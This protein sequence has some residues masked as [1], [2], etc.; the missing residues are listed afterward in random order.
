M[1]IKR[2]EASD[3]RQA[4]R[5]IREE[6]GADVVI[7]SSRRVGDRV[8]VTVANDEDV[9]S[10]TMAESSRVT[11]DGVAVSRKAVTPDVRVSEA[12]KPAALTA[13]DV[14]PLGEE[15]KILRRMLET[16]V[17]QL[18]WNDRER[19]SPFSVEVLRDLSAIGFSGDIVSKLVDGIPP[20]L[21][22]SRARRLAIARLADDVTVTGD[23]W[24][25]YGGVVA[26]V[27][28]TG[29]GKT[30][31]VAKL[32]ARWV[33]R[34]GS[35]GLALI[36]CDALR[37]GGHEQVKRLGRL[38]GAQTYT[39][40]DLADLPALLA[41]LDGRRLV[42]IDTAGMSQRDE[43]WPPMLSSLH[44]ASPQMEV[45]LTLS[46]ASQAGAIEETVSRCAATP[47][48]S[49]I[50]TKLDE[51]TSLGGILSSLIRTRLAVSYLS[52]GQRIPEDLRP[53]RALDML[54]LAVSLADRSGASVDE[55]V[56]RRR[57]GGLHGNA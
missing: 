29:V 7:L 50:L 4:L 18:A 37:F 27:G 51:T 41:R 42:L 11:A 49:C 55:D 34:H 48:T 3:M 22:L 44:A 35:T 15:L 57:V 17:A 45:A 2:Y 14:G 33:L 30:T 28:P 5:Q 38:V 54:A 21:G 40:D 43:R 1:K 25:D 16:Q 53:A 20:E 46:A 32:A 56:L 36:S 31:T 23:R 19:R 52:D 12:A 24:M 8:E 9:R 10:A 47:P 26:L 39:I 6:M 13:G